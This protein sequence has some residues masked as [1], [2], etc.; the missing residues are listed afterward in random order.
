MIKTKWKEGLNYIKKLDKLEKHLGF[1][2][3]I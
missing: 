3:Y 2:V 1:T